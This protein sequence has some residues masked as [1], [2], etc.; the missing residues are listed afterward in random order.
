MSSWSANGYGVDV[1]NFV[2]VNEKFPDSLERFLNRI[3]NTVCR[4][5]PESVIDRITEILKDKLTKGE[6]KFK[7]VQS[8]TDIFISYSRRDFALANALYLELTNMGLNVW[9]DRDDIYEK[10]GNTSLEIGKAFM[11]EIFDAI[12]TTR[13]FI[14]IFSQNIIDEIQ[15]AHPYR[16]EWKKAVEVQ[17]SKGCTFIVPISP[18]EYNYKDAGIPRDICTL[19]AEVYNPVQNIEECVKKIASDIYYVYC[20]TFN[21]KTDE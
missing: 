10:Q 6:S 7:K 18:T 13:L 14:P 8:H 21:S 12:Q 11:N 19:H 1:S 3:E 20:K 15:E 4:T 17:N 5:D 2:I 16:Q 9:F